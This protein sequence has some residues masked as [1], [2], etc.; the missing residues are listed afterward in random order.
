VLYCVDT[1]VVGFKWNDV[2]EARQVG[3]GSERHT[4]KVRSDT[5]AD[6]WRHCRNGTRVHLQTGGGWHQVR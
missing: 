5:N 1:Q 6:G 2:G 3:F 4:V